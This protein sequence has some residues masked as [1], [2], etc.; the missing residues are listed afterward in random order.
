VVVVAAAV[1]AA[2]VAV[3][4]WAVAAWVYERESGGVSYTQH[5]RSLLRSPPVRRIET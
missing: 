1:A 2:A 3:A 4:A 5:H